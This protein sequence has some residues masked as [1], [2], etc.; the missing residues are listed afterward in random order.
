MDLVEAKRKATG[1]LHKGSRTILSRI[2]WS[3]RT[4]ASWP[5]LSERFGQWQT[6]YD[7]FNRWGKA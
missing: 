2:F 6:V 5:D 1:R 7:H 3:L 4:G